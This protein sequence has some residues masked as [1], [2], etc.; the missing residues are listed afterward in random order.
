MFGGPARMFP[1]APLWLSTGLEKTLYKRSKTCNFF[2]RP[3]FGNGLAI[4]TN[5]RPSI[6]P[7]VMDVLWLSFR[8]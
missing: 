5:C 6:Y 1:R 2:G 4:G 7:S 8:S 3:Y